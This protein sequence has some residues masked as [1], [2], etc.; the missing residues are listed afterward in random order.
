VTTSLLEW[1][2]GWQDDRTQLHNFE[3]TEPAQKVQRGGTWQKVHPRMWEYAVQSKLRRLRP[4]L[5]PPE[6]ML[7]GHDEHGLAAVVTFEELD[8]PAQVELCL[9]AIARRLRGKGGGYADE[10]L[11]RA[12]DA[13][14]TRAV[15]Q[16]I[17]FVSLLTYVDE[18]NR[19]SQELCR[20][21]HLRHTAMA[22]PELQVWSGDLLVAP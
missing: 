14:T 1:H 17:G 13:I 22:G 5:A 16:E 18:R 7:T 9:A 10:M 21:F 11:T 15:E 20:R 12:L 6:F 3:C 4:P 19:Y 8:G 2:D